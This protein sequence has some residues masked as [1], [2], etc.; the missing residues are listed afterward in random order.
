MQKWGGDKISYV[1][2]IYWV[3]ADT[4]L[5]FEHVCLLY[6]QI[7]IAPADVW[8]SFFSDSHYQANFHEATI[9]G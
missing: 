9:F 4:K 3:N 2:V 8:V 6:M 5:G 1:P 7:A